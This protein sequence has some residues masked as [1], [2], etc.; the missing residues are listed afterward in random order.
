MLFKLSLFTVASI[1]CVFLRV[2]LSMNIDEYITTYL[3]F[4]WRDDDLSRFFKT[5]KV[6]HSIRVFVNKG[7]RKKNIQHRCMGILRIDERLRRGQEA[8]C[9]NISRV[10]ERVD[11]ENQKL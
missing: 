11:R 8:C 4:G 5:F 7:A 10:I 6:K 3:L 9:N 2:P 1:F